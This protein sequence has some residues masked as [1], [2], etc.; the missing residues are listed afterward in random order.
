MVLVKYW[1]GNTFADVLHN[2]I[3]VCCKAEYA[4]G[5]WYFVLRFSVRTSTPGPTLCLNIVTPTKMLV[6]W[7]NSIWNLLPEL[8]SDIKLFFYRFLK[9][10]ITISCPC[11]SWD[12]PVPRLFL[13][14]QTF[15]STLQ[16]YETTINT[17]N[18]WRNFITSYK[19][20]F[21]YKLTLIKWSARCAEL[22]LEKG[23][24]FLSE[25]LFFFLSFFT[26]LFLSFLMCAA[27]CNTMNTGEDAQFVNTAPSSLCF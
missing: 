22:W 15:H 9:P 11:C 5:R 13:C 20:L 19:W 6:R 4:L 14:Q 24:E 10:T 7:S 17:F 27:E 18:F 25:A 1:K 12:V 3:V 16:P 8:H 2:K 26:R 23:C 21:L